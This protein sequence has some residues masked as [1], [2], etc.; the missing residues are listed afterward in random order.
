MAR[1]IPI[2]WVMEP[3]EIIALTLLDNTDNITEDQTMTCG[4]TAGSSSCGYPQSFVD[5]TPRYDRK[6]KG[7]RPNQVVG[8]K[9]IIRPDKRKKAKYL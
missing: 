7:R 5:Q 6:G 8:K 1:V 2:N 4:S 9:G 3:G